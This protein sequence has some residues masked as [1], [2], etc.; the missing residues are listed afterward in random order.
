MSNQERKISKVLQPLAKDIHECLKTATGESIGFSLIVYPLKDGGRAQYIGNCKREDSARI[1]Q[2]LL[3][4]WAQGMPNVPA[5]K[6][7]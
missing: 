6:I 3:N 5:H 7:Q 1:M 4:G 2:D